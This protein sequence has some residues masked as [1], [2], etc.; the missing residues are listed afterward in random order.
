MAADIMG[1]VRGGF[2][3]SPRGQDSAVAWFSTVA[4]AAKVAA[5]T[6]SFTGRT[7]SAAAGFEPCSRFLVETVRTPA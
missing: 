1:T 5:D 4:V 6:G 3:G 2:A 7:R